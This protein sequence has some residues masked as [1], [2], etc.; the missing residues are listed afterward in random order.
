M[1]E[2]KLQEQ[3]VLVMELMGKLCISST[4]LDQACI[5][6]SHFSNGHIT[7]F[8]KTK[9]LFVNLNFDKKFTANRKLFQEFYPEFILN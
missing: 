8:D 1:P 3:N 7:H 6:V 2:N 9:L 4:Q 5:R